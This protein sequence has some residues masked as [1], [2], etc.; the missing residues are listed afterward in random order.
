MKHQGCKKCDTCIDTLLD[1]LDILFIKVDG[2][3]NGNKNSSLTFKA[4]N[5]LI[6]L[7]N[8]FKVISDSVDS[9]TYGSTPLVLLQKQIDN[10]QKK[11][12]PEFQNMLTYPLADK[13]KAIKALLTDAEN[14]NAEINGLRNKFDA[15]DT[16]LNQMDKS[17]KPSNPLF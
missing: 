4:H 3:E 13:M 10:Y 12:L 11:I 17:N 7:E 1:D 6:K 14:F 15:L 16:V 2:I 8:E 5:K 9:T